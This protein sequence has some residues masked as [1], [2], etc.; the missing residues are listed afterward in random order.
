MKVRLFAVSSVTA[1][2]FTIAGGPAGSD[3]ALPA[4]GAAP[5]NQAAPDW[6]PPAPPNP[7]W[8][9]GS[10]EPLPP[11]APGQVQP[12]VSAEWYQLQAEFEANRVELYSVHQE[13]QNTQALLQHAQAALER[14][15]A[16]YQ[17]A[18]GEQRL[19]HEQVAAAAAERDRAQSL[20]MQMKAELEAAKGTLAQNRE[21][22]ASSQTLA[23]SLTE[24]G[25]QLRGELTDR[26]RQLAALRNELQGASAGLSQ[27]Q[28]EAAAL[29]QELSRAQ[30]QAAASR[31]ELLSAQTQAGASRKELLSAQT[32][33]AASRRELVNARSQYQACH[34]QLVELDAELEGASGE[35]VSARQS[36]TQAIAARDALERALSARETELAETEAALTVVRKEAEQL[37]Q[38]AADST[39]GLATQ[40]PRNS[41]AMMTTGTMSAGLDVDQDGVSDSLDLCPET[42]NGVVVGPTGCVLNAS[43]TLEGVGF[44]Y[45]SHELTD[46]SHV[47][48]DRV[49]GIL[50]QYPDLKLEVAGHADAQGDPAYNQW[51]SQ[52]RAETVR[53]YLLTQ[54]V[55]RDNLTA[56]GYGAEQPVADNSTW[57][58]LVR[59]RRVELRR[60]P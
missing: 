34:A 17:Q 44:R 24:K 7:A 56:R 5:E 20:A 26:E 49:A 35:A 55:K 47:I 14:S 32:E 59:N 58:G 48:L 30:A 4:M 57:E 36:L 54:G 51:L 31:E 40:Q 43:M 25:A 15:Y 39:D 10:W 41:V 27:A 6:Y 42:E 21:E 3:E 22:V 2:L 53:K 8:N 46:E 13:L 1:V 19:L 18:L 60:L 9:A 12:A 38:A 23:L 33:A 45:D 50:E 11:V 29:R 28:T 37:H 52:Q 16:D